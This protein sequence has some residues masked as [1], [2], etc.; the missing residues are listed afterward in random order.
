MLS[1]TKA[2]RD[3]YYSK[4]ATLLGSIF[5]VQHWSIYLL[6]SFSFRDIRMCILKSYYLVNTVLLVVRTLFLVA[7]CTKRLSTLAQ[8]FVHKNLPFR[9]VKCLLPLH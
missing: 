3:I 5:E 6:E 8:L 1:S 2:F 9:L 7:Y 4:V